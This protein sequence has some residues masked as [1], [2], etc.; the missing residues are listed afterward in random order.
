M[1]VL[2][3]RDIHAATSVVLAVVVVAFGIAMFRDQS[4]LLGI[5]MAAAFI[6]ALVGIAKRADRHRS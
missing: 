6:Y 3:K 1:L 4:K 2:N 5:T